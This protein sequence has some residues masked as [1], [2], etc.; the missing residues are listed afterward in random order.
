MDESTFIF[1]GSGSVFFIFILLFH[2]NHVSKQNSPLWYSPQRFA[3]SHHGP[4]CLPMS[5]K[6]DTMLILVKVSKYSFIIVI[7]ADKIGIGHKKIHK[8]PTQ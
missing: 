7:C 8:H 3:A 5:H 1:S 4:F 6:K 2:E